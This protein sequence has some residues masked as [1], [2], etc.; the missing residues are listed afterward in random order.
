MPLER[1][2]QWQ[3]NVNG[4]NEN[5][6]ENALIAARDAGIVLVEKETCDG[7]ERVKLR[8]HADILQLL[9]KKDQSETIDSFISYLDELLVQRTYQPT[10]D[11]LMHL[12]VFLLSKGSEKIHTFSEDYT[13]PFGCICT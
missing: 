6:I 5:T 3:H 11:R 1:F 8:L 13:M 9:R 10:L 2:V 12:Q 7:N 4:Y